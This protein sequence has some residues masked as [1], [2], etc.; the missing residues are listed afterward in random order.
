MINFINVSL[1]LSA[2]LT[3]TCSVPYLIDVVRKKT[4]PRIVSWLNWTLL[5]GIATAAAI[6]DG[7]VAS[8]VLTGAATVETGLVV[9]LGLHYGNRKFER[10]DILCQIGAIVGLILWL[11]FNNPTI[12][13]VAT[14]AIDFLALL[15][16]LKHSWTHPEEETI[17]TFALAGLGAV[18]SVFAIT[19]WT[20]TG[21]TYPIYIT[22]ANFLL[23]SILLARKPSSSHPLSK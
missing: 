17:I 8:A 23:V 22:F 6:A 19:S 15:P 10:F 5:T 13:I 18:F 14:V 12:A 11:V 2:I 7:Q 21:L 4:K 3:V 1:F 9:I 20:I 16:T